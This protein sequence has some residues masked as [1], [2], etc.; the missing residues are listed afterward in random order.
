MMTID[1][2]QAPASVK[3]ALVSR[4][5]VEMMVTMDKMVSCVQVILFSIRLLDDCRP[6]RP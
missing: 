1:L 3:V 2:Q 6:G 5:T 4:A